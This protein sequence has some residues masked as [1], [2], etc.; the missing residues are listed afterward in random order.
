MIDHLPYYLGFNLTPGIGPARLARLIEL[1]GS[2]QAAWEAPAAALY[3]SGL[4]PK[5]CAAL[6]E[7]RR[8]LDLDTE[9]L[10]VAET[11]ARMFCIEDAGYPALLRQIPQPPPLIYVRG[12]L[13][14]RDE[15]SLAVVGTRAPSPYGKEAARR[16]S[17]D[18]AAAGVTIVSGLARGIDSIAHT[19]ALE[20][21]SRRSLCSAVAWMCPTLSAIARWLNGSPARVP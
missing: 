3:T 17:G 16:I 20:A 5:A 21:G 7:A 6:L 10:R 4:E 8:R 14:Q 13:E 9:V 15:W 12:T 18:L 11:G 19:A 2:I 1:S